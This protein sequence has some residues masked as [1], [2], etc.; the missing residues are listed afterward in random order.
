MMVTIRFSAKMSKGNNAGAGLIWIPLNKRTH[1]QKNDEVHINITKGNTETAFYSSIKPRSGNG[2]CVYIPKAHAKHSIGTVINVKIEKIDGFYAP[3]GR[4]GRVY[5]PRYIW[6]KFKLKEDDIILLRAICENK[7]LEKF[8]TVLTSG[9]LKKERLVM[10]SHQCGGKAAIFNIV[11]K[12]KKTETP[13][14]LLSLKDIRAGEI[15]AERIIL[16]HGNK[17]PIIINPNIGWGNIAYYL[18]AFFADGSKKGNSWAYSFSTTEQAQAFLRLH[19]QLIPD[20]AGKTKAFISFTARDENEKVKQSLVHYWEEKTNV[21]IQEIRFHR[22]AGQAGLK[23]NEN[24]TMVVREH[25]KLTQDYYNHLLQV[26]CNRIIKEKNTTLAID[27]LCG[28]LEGDGSP[29]AR[30]SGGII[31]S[32][33]SEDV[34]KMEKILPFTGLQYKT[35]VDEKRNKISVRLGALGLLVQLPLIYDKLFRYYPKRRR[36]FI[37]RFKKTGAVRYILGEQ[38]QAASWV[39]AFLKKK[40]VL[41]STY[42]LTPYGKT[43][44]ENLQ[45][46]IKEIQ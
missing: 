26:L 38:P 13:T 21:P 12:L 41:T 6:E 23:R 25:R 3:V 10:F 18:G 16:Y 19:E 44:K 28:V 46:M 5:F 39:K 30:E 2:F 20:A 31:I 33:N 22:S 4:D 45:M 43:I 37:S 11:K 8:C 7:K 35:Y 42:A 36:K 29:S 17:R 32:T 27:F 9:P 14:H 24:G 34:K 1:F 40:G 15:T